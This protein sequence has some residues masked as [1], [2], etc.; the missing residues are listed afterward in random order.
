[1]TLNRRTFVG[2]AGGCLAAS[3]SRT[4]VR[5][6]IRVTPNVF[7]TLE[8]IDLFCSAIEDAARNGVAA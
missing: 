1:M 5:S 4:S 7:T 6:C 2:I 8:N 3:A